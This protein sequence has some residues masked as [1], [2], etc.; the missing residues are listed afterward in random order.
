MVDSSHLNIRRG[1]VAAPSKVVTP[2][3]VVTP[4]RVTVHGRASAPELKQS[5]AE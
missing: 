3:W 2:S 4:S 1:A 5:P